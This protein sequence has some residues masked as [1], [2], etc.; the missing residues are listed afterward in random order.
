MNEDLIS[1]LCVECFSE[2][3]GAVKRYGTGIGNYVFYAEC[4]GER[5]IVRCSDEPGAYTDTVYWLD[6][7]NGIQIPVPKVIRQGM[8]RGYAYLILSYFEGQD[9]GFVY[10]RLTPTEKRAIAKEVVR[11]Q[12]RV[13]ALELED[14]GP[15]WSWYTF[16]R[17]M[18]DRAEA[19]ITGNG[20]FDPEKVER[21]RGQAG[22]LDEY[23][24]GIRPVAYLDD[25]SSKN[26][27]IH[28]G[29]ISGII[30]VD[31]M[32]V[33]DCLTYVAL[34]NMALLNLEYDTDYV[35]CILEEMGL[36]ETQK[37]A[38]IF[39]TLLYCVDFMGER[40]MTFMDKTVEVSREIIDRLN[41]IYDRLWEQWIAAWGADGGD[42][43]VRTLAIQ[44]P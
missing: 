13:A 12:E 40:G 15:D 7:L 1:Q 17:D 16:I 42:Y 22:W 20:Y 38:F 25:I 44:I 30:D 3:P 10:P 9:I 35:A 29:K 26:L 34:T 21:L 4:A 39:Y 6:R 11:I 31:W 19:R 43:A 8:F 24:R 41:G 23:F 28:N 5:Y 18:L 37:K 14:I 33:G 27:I 32:G 36:D 2:K